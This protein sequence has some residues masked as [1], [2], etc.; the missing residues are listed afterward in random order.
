MAEEKNSNK[1]RTPLGRFA[2]VSVFSKRAYDGGD[3]K[4][5]TKILFPREGKDKADLR[6]LKAAAGAAAKAK[7][8]NGL[9]KTMKSPFRDGDD[10]EWDGFE[11]M[12]FITASS[13]YQP[14][15]IN[16]QREPLMTDEE[17][18]AGCWGF[19]TVNAFGY[20]TKGNKGVSF[21]LQNLLFVRDDEPFSGRSSPEEDFEDLLEEGDGGGNDGSAAPGDDDDD[22]F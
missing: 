16:C 20:D 13:L 19:A 5:S 2:F 6:R 14:K 10:V 7:W 11:G 18:Y 17:F 21:G 12:T 22:I 9:P 1:I 15:I 4:Y 8:P 3:E